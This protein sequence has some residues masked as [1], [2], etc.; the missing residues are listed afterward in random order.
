MK[1][2]TDK[3]KR[4][5]EQY[6]NDEALSLSDGLINICDSLLDGNLDFL[7][8]TADEYKTE[9]SDVVWVNGSTAI[10]NNYDDFTIK[11]I[12]RF[13]SEFQ[14][15]FPGILTDEEIIRRIRKNL[16]TSIILDDLSKKEYL[17]AVHPS[18]EDSSVY[19]YYNPKTKMMFLDSCLASSDIDSILF[20][21]F[22][23]CITIRNDVKDP[24]LD[25]ELVTETITSIMQEKFM[26][27]KYNNYDK[28]SNK[29]ISNYAKQL[30]AIFGK[31]LYKEYILNYRDI[32][33]LFK[34][35]PNSHS[36]ERHILSKFNNLFKNINTWV[37]K[38]DMNITTNLFNTIFELNMTMFLAGFLNKHKDL[39]DK[40]KLDK[41]DRLFDLQKTPNFDLYKIL[42]TNNVNNKDLINKY[43]NLKFIMDLDR[44]KIDGN[45]LLKDKYIRFLASKNATSLDLIDYVNNPLF[46]SDNVFYSYD[47][48]YINYV[49]NQDYYN[50][51]AKLY[52]DCDINVY[53]A[54]IDEIVSSNYADSKEIVKELLTG[55]DVSK[56][57]LSKF[58]KK[59]VSSSDFIFR[60]TKNN[61]SIYIQNDVVPNI[62][63]KKNIDK[64]LEKGSMLILSEY[65]TKLLEL[66]SRGIEDVYISKKG[67]NIIVENG[68][69]VEVYKYD[70]GA[71]YY[72]PSIHKPKTVY[73]KNNL[74]S[75]TKTRSRSR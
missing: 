27:E 31:E 38:G 25:S 64:L 26:H 43:P 5:L 34:Y 61:C 14:T 18:N 74:Y 45:Y 30:E 8:S 12:Y 63:V 28:R 56:N 19:A 54:K 6:S 69:K 51:M 40:D 75:N 39:D 57:S 48:N 33:R 21:E 41:I 60:A 7:L 65:R 22:I 16:S 35:F 59:N 70:N 62:Y 4:Y 73:L 50:I 10:N 37:H 36:D 11:A 17:D 3:I 72:V 42:L 2:M 44:N 68:D 23:H 49:R 66:K 29:Y 58:K 71:Y 1:N 13:I 20:H 9:N 55:K 53:N 52:Y 24:I 47:G 15:T 67:G 46:D 32:T